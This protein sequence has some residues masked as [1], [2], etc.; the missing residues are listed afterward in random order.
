MYSNERN[1][2]HGAEF[3][4]ELSGTSMRK[5]VSSGEM[6]ANHLMRTEVA[7]MIVSFSEPFV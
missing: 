2:P 3:R 4:E 7:K 1:C 5:M 6:P